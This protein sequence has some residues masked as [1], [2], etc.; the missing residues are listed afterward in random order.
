MKIIKVFNNNVALAKDSKQVE[1][2][3]MGKGLTFQKKAGDEIDEENVQKIFV[4]PSKNFASKLSDLLNE[5]P[6]EIMTLSKDIIEMAENELKTSLNDSLYLSLSDHIHFAITRAKNDV[7]IK[8]ALMWEVKKFY[9]AEYQISR[10]A[11]AMIKDR[12]NVELPEDE[13]ASIALHIFNA[14]QDQSGMEETMTMTNMVK[15]V[16]NIVKYHYGI[17]FDEESI[18]YSRFITHLRYFAYRM[19]RGEVNND[20]N[21][22]L[23]E[24]VKQQYPEAYQCTSKVELYLKNKYSMEMTKDELAYFMIHI[25]RVSSREQNNR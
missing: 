17:E 23:F 25:H 9:K 2:V 1:M 11:L 15:D 6:Y 18:N 13:I 21:D 12:M 5:I 10:T 8:N 3:V 22:I 7:P 16:T 19:L 20:L 4:T 14:R 24:Q